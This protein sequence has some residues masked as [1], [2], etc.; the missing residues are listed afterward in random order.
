MKFLFILFLLPLQLAAQDL[1][2]VW[3]GKMYNDTTK[4]YI[5]YELAISEY[6]GKLS[7]YSHTTFIID[8]AE[9][10]GVKSLKV[11]NKKNAV[12]AE[13]EKL[14][15]NNYPVPPV[16]G[17]RTLFMLTYSQND[18]AEILQGS[19]KTNITK[20]YNQFTGS[21][22]LEKKK[23]IK[24]TLIVAK[25]NQLG[26]AEKL[27]FV[28]PETFPGTGLAANDQKKESNPAMQVASQQANENNA[29]R[30]ILPDTTI[31]DPAI[32]IVGLK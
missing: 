4:E 32:T 22:Y 20:Q 15:Y 10:I 11:S 14:I 31:T 18:T 8:G 12:L 9:N 24:E 5:R 29:P 19:W 30:R 2:G 7:G 13:D 26:L 25:L 23:K 3:T 28:S 16:K 17:I 27:S 21:V 6:H 1:T